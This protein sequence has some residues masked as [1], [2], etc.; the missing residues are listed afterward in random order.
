MRKERG[1]FRKE[2]SLVIVLKLVALVTI[3]YMCF[4]HPENFLEKSALIKHFTVAISE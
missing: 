2:I 4:H 3:W 1:S